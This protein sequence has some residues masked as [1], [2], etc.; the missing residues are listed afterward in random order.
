MIL[1]SMHLPPLSCS[2]SHTTCSTF[3]TSSNSYL[4]KIAPSHSD[5]LAV[6]FILATHIFWHAIFLL[7]YNINPNQETLQYLSN[8]TA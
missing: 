3:T 7:G 2:P 8:Q 6:R 4:G 1:K 5:I